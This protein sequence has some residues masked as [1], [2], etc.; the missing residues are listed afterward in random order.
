MLTG[1]RSIRAELADLFQETTGKVAG[2]QALADAV[3]VLEG[4]ARRNEPVPLA[5]RVAY[6]DGAAWLDLGTLTGEAAKITPAGWEVVAAPPIL[7]RRTALSGALPEPA[8]GGDLAEL[9]SLLNVVPESRPVLLAWLVS[10][11]LPDLPHPI[12]ALVGEQ[13]T[14]KST[15]S[16]MLAGLLDPSPAQL[17]KPPRDVEGWT[18]AAAGSWLVGV[19]NLSTIPAWWSDSLCRAVTGDGDVRRRL[20]SDADL[21][22]FA[23]RRVVLL[24]GIDLGGVRDDLAERLLTVELHRITERRYDAD[25]AAAWD[26]AHPRILGALLD[27]AA[28]VLKVLPDVVLKDPP[29]MADFARILAAVDQIQGTTG[30]ATYGRLATDLAADAVTGDPVLSAIA[31]TILQ[32]WEGTA[33]E[34]LGKLGEPSPEHR[35]E[36]PKGARAMTSLLRRR[37]PAL[38]RLGWTVDDLG[39]GGHDK[40]I[41]FKIAPAGSA[42]DSDDR[43]RRAGDVRA[44]E[45]DGGRRAGD[46]AGRRPPTNPVLTCEDSANDENAGDAG[47]KS[48]NLLL[49][50]LREEK[51]EQRSGDTREGPYSSPASPASPHSAPLGA[52]PPRRGYFGG[53]GGR[54]SDCGFHHDTQAPLADAWHESRTA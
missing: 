34:L 22:V 42:A 45:G 49:D 2:Q 5:L 26:D 33:G 9:W 1:S 29:R 39:R 31:F 40:L 6:V 36:W 14:G 23:F 25:L 32:S 52:A 37:A 54:C 53:I 27:L 8:A 47:D 4:R 35:K 46:S 30:L 41:R 24:N 20:Y 3:L 43:G 21:T 16:R 48:R 11:L 19:D 15:A 50:L 38:R 10:A 7:F 12:A 51:E 44:T 18:T 28:Q 17:R 13:G